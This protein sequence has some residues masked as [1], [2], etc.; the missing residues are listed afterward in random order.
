MSAKALRPDHRG[1]RRIEGDHAVAL[2]LDGSNAEFEIIMRGARGD[3][4]IIIVG[5][6]HHSR[7]R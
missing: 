4:A 5:P 2:D 1:R 3:H 7:S 6:N